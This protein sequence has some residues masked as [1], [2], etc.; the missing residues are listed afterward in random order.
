MSGPI[1]DI[2]AARSVLVTG[3]SGFIG[4]HLVRR[5]SAR[6]CQVTC[7][8]R[9]I[10]GANPLTSAGA[11]QITGDVTDRASV[12]RALAAASADIVFHAAGLVRA[13][14][15]RDFGRVNEAGVENV[16]AA[17]AERPNPPVLVVISSLAAAGPCLA[18]Q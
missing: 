7:F 2:T 12:A 5:V 14:R 6:G 15:A 8:V 17:C 4:S 11:Q 1:V 18:D 3:A 16:A 13:V 10:R 9:G